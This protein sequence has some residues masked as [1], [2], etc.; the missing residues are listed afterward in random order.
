[1]F[2]PSNT[3]SLSEEEVSI[4]GPFSHMPRSHLTDCDIASRKSAVVKVMSPNTS[5]YSFCSDAMSLSHPKRYRITNHSLLHISS[6]III[7][8]FGV[9]HCFTTN[10]GFTAKTPCLSQFMHIL[11]RK[12][13]RYFTVGSRIYIMACTPCPR[14]LQYSN[15]IIAIRSSS[16]INGP[17]HVAH[18]HF[19]SLII[20]GPSLLSV[21]I[22]DRQCDI[23]DQSITSHLYIKPPPPAPRQL[24]YCD[25]IAAIRFGFAWF[26]GPN[27]SPAIVSLPPMY[28]SFFP[29]NEVFCLI[30]EKRNF[31]M[32]SVRRLYAPHLQRK[33]NHSSAIFVSL[34]LKFAPENERSLTDLSVHK[35]SAISAVI[36]P[37]WSDFNWSAPI[38]LQKP[39]ESHGKHCSSQILP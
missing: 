23:G 39:A 17:D 29:C 14:R 9:K 19:V 20:Q 26:N 30:K 4:F 35:S 31:S 37:F 12:P 28:S 27:L 38:E 25:F 21:L 16:R 18:P 11:H 22:A 36:L 24:R 10:L 32:I 34:W 1:M 15:L 6:F 13:Y 2:L 33:L 3:I 7:P 8:H 5:L